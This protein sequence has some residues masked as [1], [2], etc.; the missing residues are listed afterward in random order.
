MGERS[1]DRVQELFNQA[2]AVPP[3]QRAAF[4][5]AACADDPAIRAEVESLLACD[6][7]LT[8]GGNDE[9]LL[10]SPLVRAPLPRLPDTHRLWLPDTHRLGCQTPTVWG[11]QTPTLS[12]PLGV[13][14]HRVARHPPFPKVML[15]PFWAWFEKIS[16]VARH[17]PFP[18]LWR[19]VF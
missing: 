5:E 4:L 3:P 15:V 1:G 7:D 17:P 2:V 10:K 9:G 11:C 14:R 6:V 19:G 16:G 13:A 8:E 18:T 12:H